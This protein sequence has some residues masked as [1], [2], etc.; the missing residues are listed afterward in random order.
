MNA[1]SALY[2]IAQNDSPSLTIV[3]GLDPWSEHFKK[4]ITQCLQKS[5][6]NRPSAADLLQHD[7]ISHLSDRKA[8]VDLIRK[9]KDIVRD[10][11]NLQ[12]RKM[13]K[14]IMTESSSTT[15]TGLSG[16][17]TSTGGGAGDS[18]NSSVVAVQSKTTSSSSGG[19]VSTTTTTTNVNRE[20]SESTSTTTRNLK[21]DVRLVETTS[22]VTSS[23]GR[24][25][26]RGDANSPLDDYD[27]YDVNENDNGGDEGDVED[28]ADDNN[29]DGDGDDDD[30]R[31]DDDD[32]DLDNNAVDDVIDP[33]IKSGNPANDVANRLI[34][35]ASFKGNN[36]TS[37]NTGVKR[38]PTTNSIKSTASSVLQ[39][40]ATSTTLN[41]SNQ[42]DELFNSS[43]KSNV[44]QNQSSNSKS[45]SQADDNE[46]INLG[47]SL[48]RR[49]TLF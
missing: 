3:A 44:L 47:N 2:H 26:E 11:D 20:M 18:N 30:D 24:A 10:L 22:A 17:H 41:S 31:D 4:F 9:T 27:N 1:M 12:Y 25:A 23:H 43:S 40:P 38:T 46:I 42:S 36:N 15:S 32:D 45:L 28:E 6:A 29:N 33:M 35:N 37:K 48:K 13:K 19:G 49:V 8:L 39:L 5:P 34:L 16:N 14:I 7:F 21:T